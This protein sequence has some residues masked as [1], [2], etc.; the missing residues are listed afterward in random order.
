LLEML[1]VLVLVAGL[2]GL[3]A[4]SALRGVDAARERGAVAD[5]RALLGS[6]PLRSY[7][8]GVATAWDGA[9]LQAALPEWPQGWGLKTAAP[10]RYSADGAAAGG[11]LLV[12]RPGR[13]PLRLRVQAL[14]G[15]VV[16]DGEP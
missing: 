12:Q 13:E 7:G 5:V 2:A 15:K 10:L 4:P 3:V 6:L 16:V 1:V 8:A 9:Q 11:T 14:T